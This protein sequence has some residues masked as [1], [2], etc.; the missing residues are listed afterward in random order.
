MESLARAERGRRNPAFAVRVKQQE[1]RVLW[2]AQKVLSKG[3]MTI[4]LK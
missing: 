2:L 3:W 1:T 4:F